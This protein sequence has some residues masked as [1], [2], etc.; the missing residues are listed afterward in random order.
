M[1]TMTRRIAASTALLAAPVLIALGT[2]SASYADTGITNNGPS[3]S[4]P[5]H[6][7]TFPQ[8]HNF[9]QPGTPAHHHHQSW[10]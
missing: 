6:H 7:Q 2:A 5:T 4:A 1:T 9:P 10:F 8:Q 3:V